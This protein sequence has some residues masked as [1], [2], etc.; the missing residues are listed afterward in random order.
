MVIY[1]YKA[2]IYKDKTFVDVSYV[3]IMK[4]YF[5][6]YHRRED[7]EVKRNM[8]E[9]ALMQNTLI[10]DSKGKQIYA[11]DYVLYEGKIYLV[12]F[13]KNDDIGKYF[14]FTTKNEP[15][16]ELKKAKLLDSKLEIV[17]NFYSKKDK[18]KEESIKRAWGNNGSRG[19]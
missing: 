6:E 3:S 7:Y 19:N 13:V 15:L 2:Y 14:L 11:K 18:N 1:P 16:I 8:K 5:I 4:N 10:T 12:D 9:G 17:G